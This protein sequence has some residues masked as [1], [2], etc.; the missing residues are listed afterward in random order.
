MYKN[1][2]KIKIKSIYRDFFWEI[3]FIYLFIFYLSTYYKNK[4]IFIYLY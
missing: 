1:K 4:Y 2:K 3:S